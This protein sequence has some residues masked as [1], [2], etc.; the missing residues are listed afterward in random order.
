MKKVFEAIAV[1][2]TVLAAFSVSSASWIFFYQAKI[3]KS[4]YKLL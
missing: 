1:I 3:P 2:L 4:V